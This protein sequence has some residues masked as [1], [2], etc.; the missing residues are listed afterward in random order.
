[1]RIKL[2]VKYVADGEEFELLDNC[3]L[4]S[5]TY[6]SNYF[7]KYWTLYKIVMYQVKE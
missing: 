6:V 7:S 4:I 2:I 1:M 5:A 3:K